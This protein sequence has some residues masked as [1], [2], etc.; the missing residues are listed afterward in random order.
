MVNDTMSEQGEQPSTVLYAALV[1]NIRG[2]AFS[3]AR[4]AARSQEFELWRQLVLEHD[5][6][7]SAKRMTML[8]GILYQW[9]GQRTPFLELLQ[10]GEMHVEQ[11]ALR[12]IGCLIQCAVRYSPELRSAVEMQPGAAAKVSDGQKSLKDADYGSCGTRS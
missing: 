10:I 8:I 2:H 5:G 12:T 9:T 1:C 7:T 3:V 11:H 4:R 6:D